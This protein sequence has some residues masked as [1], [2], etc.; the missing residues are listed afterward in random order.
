M[1]KHVKNVYD[2]DTLNVSITANDTWGKTHRPD[3]TY[4][5]LNEEAALTTLP[6]VTQYITCSSTSKACYSCCGYPIRNF[7][8]DMTSCPECSISLQTD[9]ECFNCSIN[10]SPQWH[11]IDGNICCRS[12]YTYHKK[13]HIHRPKQIQNSSNKRIYHK[14]AQCGWQLKLV[15]YSDN[16][17]K[18]KV[19]NN[20]SNENHHLEN[21]QDRNM[22]TYSNRDSWDLLRITTKATPQQ[23][24]H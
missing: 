12:C 24:L 4:I 1:T 3:E 22:S 16:M 17:N 10:Q 23:I 21:T 13:H 7:N 11:K 19:Y 18:W 14:H 8:R 20:V 15:L 6:V 9:N 5:L 2:S